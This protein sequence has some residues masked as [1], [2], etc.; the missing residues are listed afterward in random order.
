M[1]IELLDLQMDPVDLDDGYV[2]EDIR[3]LPGR[4]GVVAGRVGAVFPFGDG[5][6][7]V[8]VL[9]EAV[10]LGLLGGAPPRR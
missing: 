3:V 8:D 4:A 1:R 2:Q 9:R 7:P 10:L 6:V 5:L